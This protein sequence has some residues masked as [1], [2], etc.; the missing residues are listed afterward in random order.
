MGAPAPPL[1]QR[2]ISQK[3]FQGVARI[4]FPGVFLPLRDEF[5]PHHIEILAV[6]GHVFFRDG[7]RASI[8]AL[9]RDT[10]VV[11]LAIEANP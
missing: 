8:A 11:A 1:S 10:G 7:V 9:L 3:F 6:I 4:G 2:S 5:A